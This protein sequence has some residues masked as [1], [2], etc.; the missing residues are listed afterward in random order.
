M[1]SSA[2]YRADLRIIPWI[3]LGRENV[4]IHWSLR[5]VGRIAG[6]LH[7]LRSTTGI[8]VGGFEAEPYLGVFV[9]VIAVVGRLG[10]VRVSQEA[11]GTELI[12][13][14]ISPSC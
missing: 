11:Q 3:I 13:F 14:I 1:F 12:I 5:I 8:A 4:K 2:V 10:E 6:W 9:G 7:E